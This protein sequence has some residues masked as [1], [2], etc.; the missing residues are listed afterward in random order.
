MNSWEIAKKSFSYPSRARNI[1]F[2]DFDDFAENV[3]QE[4]PEFTDDIVRSLL[5][6]DFF[7]L[8]NAYTKSFM[9][10]LKINTLV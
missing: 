10:D 4:N 5:E 3:N 6:G 9:Y 2:Y 8:K 1:L 7:I